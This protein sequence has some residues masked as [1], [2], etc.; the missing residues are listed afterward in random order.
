LAQSRGLKIIGIPTHLTPD[1]ED[2]RHAIEKKKKKI[3]E[4]SYFRAFLWR[5]SR[6][7]NKIAPRRQL[8]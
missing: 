1:H 6:P 3:N 5:V 4:I 2:L 8:P 7:I